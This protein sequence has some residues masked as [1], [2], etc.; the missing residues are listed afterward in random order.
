MRDNPSL[1][2]CYMTDYYCFRQ[3][4]EQIDVLLNIND[5]DELREQFERDVK[6]KKKQSYVD[7]LSQLQNDL[8]PGSELTD[9][10]LK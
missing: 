8:S 1:M 10:S 7:F 5:D 4:E 3:F 2:S 9:T 6:K